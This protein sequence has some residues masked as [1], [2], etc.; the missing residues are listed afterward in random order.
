MQKNFQTYANVKQKKKKKT[1]ETKN[2]NT[3]VFIIFFNHNVCV[4]YPTMHVNKNLTAFKILNN[5]FIN[6]Y[7]T[8]F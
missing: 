5:A 6:I 1:K 8:Y 7:K 4:E 2:I 3:C